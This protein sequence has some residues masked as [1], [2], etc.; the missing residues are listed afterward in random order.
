[1]LV[2]KEFG[3][4]EKDSERSKVINN[5]LCIL[6][7]ICSQEGET[8]VDQLNKESCSP[9]TDDLSIIIPENLVN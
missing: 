7:P 9:Y 5:S 8:V 2:D 4:S 1:M 6:F 3:C